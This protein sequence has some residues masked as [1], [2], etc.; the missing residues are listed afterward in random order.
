MKK[1]IA[2]V[3][4]GL[5]TYCHADNLA[6]QIAGFL[7]HYSVEQKKKLKQYAVER[8]KILESL[9]LNRQC[10]LSDRPLLINVESYRDCKPC[11]E[12]LC[13]CLEWSNMQFYYNCFVH[14]QVLNL[15]KNEL[16]KFDNG[17]LLSMCYKCSKEYA[18]AHPLFFEEAEI[19]KIIH[20]VFI[21]ILTNHIGKDS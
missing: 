5:S 4:I 7:S 1:L 12:D 8:Y 14:Q 19:E 20:E 11:I 15:I 3:L 2:V 17:K 18:L 16:Q 10:E 21:A 6:N 13:E 9:L